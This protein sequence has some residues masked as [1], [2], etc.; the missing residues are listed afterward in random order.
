M[1]GLVYPTAVVSHFRVNSVLRDFFLFKA[2]ASHSRAISTFSLGVV[3]DARCSTNVLLRSF[4]RKKILASRL[5]TKSTP[6]QA[7]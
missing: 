3:Y 4:V 1:V 7:D 6:G 2:K 5:Y